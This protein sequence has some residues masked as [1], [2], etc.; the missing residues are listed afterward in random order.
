MANKKKSVKK[1][2]GKGLVDQASN[3]PFMFLCSL[4]R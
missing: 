1:A 3:Q 4:L 2:A